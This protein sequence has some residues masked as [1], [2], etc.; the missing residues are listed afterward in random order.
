LSLWFRFGLPC[1]SRLFLRLRV[2]LRRRLRL[3]GRLVSGRSIRRCRFCLVRRRG[4]AWFLLACV[5]RIARSS[6]C[7]IRRCWFGFARRRGFGSARPCRFG[8]ARRRRFGPTRPCR[9]RLPR[10]RRFGSARPCRFR[11][12]W[13]RWSRL[14]GFCRFE[15][16]RSR[17][18]GLL[19]FRRVRPYWSVRRT[20]LCWR[21]FWAL[22]SWPISRT[23]VPGPVLRTIRRPIVGWTI[24]P[25]A[26]VA[27]PV[28]PHNRS[29]TVRAV[30]RTIRIRPTAPITVIVIGAARSPVP[31]PSTPSPR[32]VINEQRPNPNSHSETD[33]RCRH[34][35][36]GGFILNDRG[37]I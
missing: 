15:S 34:D 10:L 28:G 24:A 35:G 25:I 30:R 3:R 17:R 37:I 11:F 8:F 16:S 1:Q 32:L 18:F 29:R 14:A 9:F 5:P 7:T 36:I 19:G 27:W 33:Q 2:L 12:S 20:R 21:R 4:S 13:L 6:W 23:A 22:A 26:A 31:P